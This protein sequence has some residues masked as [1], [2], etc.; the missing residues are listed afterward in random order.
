MTKILALICTSGGE[1]IP[2]AIKRKKVT[3]QP[4]G[5]GGGC[6]V[7]FTQ[8]H[9]PLTPVSEAVTK[10]YWIFEIYILDG[11]CGG[12]L[13]AECKKYHMENTKKAV[14]LDGL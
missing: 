10:K 14:A 12:I 1:N 3:A 5:S 11:S 6:F 4:I 8:K 13:R 9:T 7:G 2:H